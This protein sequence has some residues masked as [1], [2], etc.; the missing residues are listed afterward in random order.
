[1]AKKNNA[2]IKT[3]LAM[4]E[5]LKLNGVNLAYFRDT[6]V[7]TSEIV[8]LST[9]SNYELVEIYNLFKQYHITREGFKDIYLYTNLD[10]LRIMGF[11][12][13]KS[14]I[15]LWVIN[16]RRFTDNIITPAKRDKDIRIMSKYH[17][18]IANAAE[19]IQTNN[20]NTLLK[21]LCDSAE[22]YSDFEKRLKQWQGMAS[23]KKE[24]TVDGKF[25]YSKSREFFKHNVYKTLP[26]NKE[27]LLAEVYR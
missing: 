16:L 15:G 12:F 22:Y 24:F 8:D 9:C 23:V 6:V 5:F 26:G 21:F 7:K 19:R 17:D 25:G 2:T 27:Y 14:E 11:S 4:N 3:N 13:P 10:I 20:I 18:N 1:M